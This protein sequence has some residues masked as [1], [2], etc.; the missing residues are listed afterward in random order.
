MVWCP[1]GT[2]PRTLRTTTLVLGVVPRVPRVVPRVLGGCCQDTRG[3]S[4]G[5]Q[6]V[7]PRVLGVV[8]RIVGKGPRY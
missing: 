7:V 4:P 6:A 2:N 1:P 5:Y 8:P 3:W